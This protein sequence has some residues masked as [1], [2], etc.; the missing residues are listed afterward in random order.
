MSEPLAWTSTSSRS[1]VCRGDERGSR[2]SRVELTE[3]YPDKVDDED[4]PSGR[5]RAGTC[6]DCADVLL[7]A[8]LSPEIEEYEETEW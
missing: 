1:S 4:R 2:G 7:R 5:D 6:L 3:S 8:R